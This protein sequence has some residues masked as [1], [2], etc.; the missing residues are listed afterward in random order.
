[1]R[2][3][4]RLVIVSLSLLLQSIVPLY[5]EYGYNLPVGATKVS[6][7][8]YD[9]HMMILYIC[10]AIGFVVY[11]ALFFAVYKHRKSVGA[12]AKMIHGSLFA[13]ILW[14]AIP[15]V[16]VIIMLI[17]AVRI[18]TE[19][20]D[21]RE[22][23]MN[24]KIT[25]IQWKWR[26]DYLEEGLNFYSNLSTP[27]AQI[28]GQEPKGPHYLYEVDKPLVLP[29]HKKV[30]LLFTSQDVNHSWWVPDL[31]IK[32]DCIPGYIG[33]GWVY[34]EKP[35]TYRGQC[36]ELCGMQHGYMPIVVEAK[37]EKDYMAWLDEQKGKKKEVVSTLP[38]EKLIDLGKQVYTT[39]CAVCHQSNGKGMPPALKALAGSEK[40]TGDPGCPISILLAGIE[41]SAMQSFADQLNDV[42][43]AAVLSYIRNSWGNDDKDLYGPYAGDVIQPIEV[44][45]MRKAWMENGEVHQCVKMK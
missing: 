13:E 44:A 23:E 26:Y 11:M 32:H 33:E 3:M 43:I 12:K 6:H 14:T 45:S 28:L 41:G 17:P 40:A 2:L 21:V 37:S 16:L 30:K 35:G 42:D 22:P 9:L 29:V 20:V 25:G 19:I 15:F 38:P 5:A 8:I 27:M 18:L 36:T 24:V 39:N 31:G 1:M 10:L 7:K 4:G 34:I